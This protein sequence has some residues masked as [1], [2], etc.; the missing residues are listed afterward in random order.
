MNTNYQLTD[1]QGNASAKIFS[2]APGKS[3]ITAFSNTVSSSLNVYFVSGAVQNQLTVSVDSNGNNIYNEP[4]DYIV[5]TAS[6]DLS[7]I[8]V[9]FTDGAGNPL[10]GKTITLSSDSSLASLSQTSLTTDNNGNAYAFA[11]FT[12][13]Q[14]GP[15]AN[16]IFVDITASASDGTAGTI[17]LQ[18]QPFIVGSIQFYSD[19]YS[20]STGGTANLTACLVSNDDTPIQ[21]ANLGIT[22][23]ASPVTSGTMMPFAF[24]DS[25][26]CAKNTFTAITGGTDT[27]TASF[28][29][30]SSNLTIMAH[31]VPQALQVTPTTASANVGDSVV[32]MVTGGTAPY[33]VVSLTP[34]LTNPASWN[35]AA[36]GTT[37]EVT[38]VKAGNASIMVTDSAGAQ[39]QAALTVSGTSTP[40]SSTL[41]ATPSSVSLVV[42]QPQLIV[43][44]GG[45]APYI[46]T[47]LSPSLTN[48]TSWNIS[49]SGGAFQVTGTNPGNALI[50]IVDSTGAQ[51]QAT[52]NITTT[53]STSL[54]ATPQTVSLAVGEPQVVVITG[55]TAPY[56]VTSLN[57]SLTNPTSWSV[58]SSG[59]SFQVTPAAAGTA[60][61]NI[62]DSKG[63]QIQVTLTIQ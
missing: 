33:S 57:P 49:A 50:N 48:P 56:T 22:F 14:G 52:L 46:A 34:S 13:P 54:T 4:A 44:T 59:G 15:L 32:F 26:G 58:T 55:G 18:L 8:R 19:S 37:F 43:V 31:Q 3:S 63:T 16:T 20:I 6:G 7:K 51:I 39:V 53:L 30:V 23:T 61:I 45:T 17:V 12:N 1:G 36:S 25:T 2:T 35:L 29:S 5:S 10:V 24:T 42:S 9:T 47:S 40:P 21:M 41:T 27:L 38:G 11:T 28:T 60:L 62:V